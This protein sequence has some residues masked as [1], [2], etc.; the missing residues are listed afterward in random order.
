MLRM[1]SSTNCAT[2]VPVYITN[3][4]ATPATNAGWTITFDLIGGTNGLRYDI[5]STT[6]LVGTNIA[7]S[8]WTWLERGPTCSTYQYTN[9]PGPDTF[10][11]VGTPQDTDGD[12]LTDAFEL[13]VSKTDVQVGVNRIQTEN[14]ITGTTNWMLY[15]PISAGPSHGWPTN[16]ADTTPELQGFASATSVNVG[17][18]ID[19]YVDVR[20]TN[21]VN[22]TIEVFRLGWYS[23]QRAL[24]TSQGGADEN[25]RSRSI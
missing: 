14:A 6:N 11:V 13:L 23:C 12:G 22:F 9:Q 4:V 8:Q 7:N 21:D 10:Y 19:L 1:L 2:N 16:D 5:F 17:E 3:M 15:N 24:K 20:R 25:R 18:S